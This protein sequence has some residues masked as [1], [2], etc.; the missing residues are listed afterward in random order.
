MRFDAYAATFDL[1]PASIYHPIAETFPGMYSDQAQPRWGYTH[2]QQLH[3]AGN[4]ALLFHR[5][6]GEATETHLTAQGRWSAD[7]ATHLRTV[8]PGHRVTRADVCYDLERP[9]LW[10]WL[11]P[12][13]LDI[14]DQLRLTVDHQ[15]DWHRGIKGRT[16]YIGSTRS[17]SF[18][19]IYEKGKQLR[20]MGIDDTAPLDL[21][22]LEVQCRPEKDFRDI[23]WTATPRQLFSTSRAAVRLLSIIANQDLPHQAPGN[24][25]QP[26]KKLA[27]KFRNLARQYGPFLVQ[28]ADSLGPTELVELLRNQVAA[29]Q[30]ADILQA[31]SVYPA[32]PQP[33]QECAPRELPPIRLDQVPP[34]SQIPASCGGTFADVRTDHET[35]R[36]P[37]HADS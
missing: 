32:M 5:Q 27:V 15:G 13:A 7:L 22:R 20:S 30:S 6:K 14:A 2:A 23:A 25:R 11:I 26:P 16:L 1:D 34:V 17:A 18:L 37:T 12:I 8:H 10:D 33:E 28:L 29:P 24:T 35:P 3:Y 9:G 21:V 4:T 19:R 36:E 31:R